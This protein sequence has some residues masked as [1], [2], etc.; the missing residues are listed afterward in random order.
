MRALD[1]DEEM[2]SLPEKEELLTSKPQMNFVG[3]K[4]CNGQVSSPIMTALQILKF[5]YRHDR[6]NFSSELV[7]TEEEFRIDNITPDMVEMVAAGKFDE[8]EE[9]L[10]S[11]PSSTAN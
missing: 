11:M 9:L 1:T 8:L 3:C 4:L 5:S 6:L 2:E 10:T 7:A